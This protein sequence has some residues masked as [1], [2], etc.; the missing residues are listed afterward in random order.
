M[1]TSPVR[2]G[3]IGTTPYAETHMERIAR[4]PH[5]VLSAVAG[6]NPVRASAVGERHDVHGVF[7]SYESLLASGFVDAVAVV[8][9]DE[10]HEPIARAAFDA[11]IHVLCEKPLS[12][13]PGSAR[14]M[15]DAAEQSG[16]VNMS[17]FALRTTPQ[18]RYL[19]SLLRAGDIGRVLSV[20]IELSHG[21]FRG[22][23]YNWRFDTSL[24]GGVVADLG[25]YVFDLARWY[26]GEI[27]AVVTHGAQHVYR[28]R[29]DGAAYPSADDSAFGV[30]SFANGAHGSFH[31]S[32]VS[33]V[34]AGKQR[35]VVKLQGESGRLE[36]VHTFAGSRLLRVGDEE[37]E[38]KVPVDFDAPDGDAEFI[39]AI[40]SG[41]SVKPDFV[42]GWR[43]QQVVAA[44]EESA[45]SGTWIEVKG[46]AA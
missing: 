33:H 20:D 27:Q 8:A 29:P 2:V 14:R 21:F 39:D 18:H 34:G 26:V 15:V 13:T 11:G 6:R 3:V 12:R 30:L 35:N 38:L 36:L 19:H 25:C 5:A 41:G 32:V 16:L 45:R 7:D 31:V 42:D 46:E 24:G 23:E 17:Y 40:V 28:P 44:A 22:S 37:E 43:V 9:P 1:T 10:L 4:H